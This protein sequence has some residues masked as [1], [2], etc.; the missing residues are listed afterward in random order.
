M[1]LWLHFAGYR[2]DYLRLAGHTGQAEQLK[3]YGDCLL[4]VNHVTESVSQL[5]T[6]SGADIPDAQPKEH[7]ISKAQRKR[8]LLFGIDAWL[9]TQ[10]LMVWAR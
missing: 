8:V 9:E 1:W 5:S 10:L 7:R 3:D 6:D 2:A 4:Q